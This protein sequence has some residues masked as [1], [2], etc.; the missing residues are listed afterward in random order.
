MI[1]SFLQ[2]IKN[3]LKNNFYKLKDLWGI[4]N[5][6]LINNANELL[7]TASNCHNLQLLQKN[8]SIS[9]IKRKTSHASQT[10]TKEDET[11]SIVC[12]IFFDKI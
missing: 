12:F 11:S 5:K 9:V 7:E 10:L 1:Y 3:C 2:S 8:R 6:L 4:P